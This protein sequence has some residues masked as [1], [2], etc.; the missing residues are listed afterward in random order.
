MLSLIQIVY[1]LIAGILF[2]DLIDDIVQTEK[3]WPIAAIFGMAICWIIFLLWYLLAKKFP[4][5]NVLYS[6]MAD[7][8]FKTTSVYK[9]AK[10]D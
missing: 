10:Y 2:R 3:W 6:K 1:F 8:I 4:T 9:K 7:P 5:L